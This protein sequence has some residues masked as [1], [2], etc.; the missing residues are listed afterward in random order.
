MSAV[1][2]TMSLHGP[3]DLR[4]KLWLDNCGIPLILP[5]VCMTPSGIL[6]LP[7]SLVEILSDLKANIVGT[8]LTAR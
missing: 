6:C 1:V 5:A 4:M 8:G 2:D 7:L 3:A